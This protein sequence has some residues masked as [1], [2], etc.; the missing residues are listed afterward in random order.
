MHIPAQCQRR[1]RRAEENR[2]EPP[3]E[4]MP[5]SVVPPVEPR[6]VTQIKPLQRQAQVGPSQFDDQVVMI[7][8]QDKAM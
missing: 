1:G 8:H 4:Q 6:A 2:L 5:D 3:L 7:V